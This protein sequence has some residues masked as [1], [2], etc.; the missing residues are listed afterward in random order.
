ME[1]I[2]WGRP[3]GSDDAIDDQPLYTQGKTMADVERVKAIAAKDGW[4]SFHVQTIDGSLPD[5][6]GALTH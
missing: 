2:L 4:H 3:Q 5:F 6:A 1:L